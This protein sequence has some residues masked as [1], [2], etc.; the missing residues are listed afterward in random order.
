MLQV[1][2]L[3]TRLSEIDE[4]STTEVMVH[5]VDLDTNEKQ[6]LQELSDFDPYKTTSLELQKSGSANALSLQVSTIHM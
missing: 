5:Q 2:N 6:E 4:D 1:E 3:I